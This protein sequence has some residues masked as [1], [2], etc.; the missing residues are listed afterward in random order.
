M[1]Y[2]LSINNLEE[3]EL[4][5]EPGTKEAA[6]RGQENDRVERNSIIKIKKVG[7]NLFD[8]FEYEVASDDEDNKDRV[9][10]DGEE[11]SPR[12]SEFSEADNF[13]FEE[14]IEAVR[15]NMWDF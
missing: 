9:E 1:N 10:S 13:L 6:G 4:R 3:R 11:E 14:D 5:N 2:N 15:N 12:E 7:F 8:E